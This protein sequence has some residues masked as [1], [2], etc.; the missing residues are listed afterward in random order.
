LREADIEE[1]AGALLAARGNPL[2]I[3]QPLRGSQVVRRVQRRQPPCGL[4]ISMHRNEGPPQVLRSFHVLQNPGEESCSAADASL[5]V[6][7]SHVSPCE[8]HVMQMPTGPILVPIHPWI[9]YPVLKCGYS[10]LASL[11]EGGAALPQQRLTWAPCEPQEWLTWAPCE[12][13]EW[14]TWV[15]LTSHS[16]GDCIS[17]GADSHG[18]YSVLTRCCSIP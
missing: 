5:P 1:G 8:P 3:R 11:N 4:Q 13:Q 10:V 7:S 9:D 18:S 17:Q 16:K 14:L 12:A 15:L 6:P 2:P